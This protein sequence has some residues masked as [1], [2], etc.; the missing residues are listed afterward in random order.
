MSDT[1]VVCDDAGRTFGRGSLAVVAVHSVSCSVGACSRVALVGPSGSGKSTLLQMMAG[2]DAPTSGSVTW[3]AWE[4][5]PFQDPTR[6]GMVFQGLSLIPSLSAAENVAFPLILQGVVHEEAMAQAIESLDRLGIASL[7]DKVPD[8]LSGG[9]SQRVAVARVVTTGPQL[10][11]AD[12]PTGQLDRASGE[13]VID[14]LLEAA[15]HLGAGLVLS[16]HDTEVASRM[17]ETW[18]MRDG[19][20]VGTS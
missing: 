8:E 15:D 1:L 14:V 20:L 18:R 19:E 2:L 16:T 4:S 5:G 3:P 9:Q 7:A 12:E 11:F 17:K 6:A 13:R 10:I